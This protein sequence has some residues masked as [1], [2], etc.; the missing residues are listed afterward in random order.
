MV[1]LP[2]LARPTTTTRHPLRPCLPSVLSIIKYN[3]RC[4]RRYLRSFYP[5]LLSGSV[6]VYFL[7]PL[8]LYF[9][10]VPMLHNSKGCLPGARS[11]AP[12]PS[13]MT[14]TFQ[15]KTQ[16]M[17]QGRRSAIAKWCDS[18]E[19]RS[20]SV[21]LM[22]R[23]FRDRPAFSQGD[24]DDRYCVPETRCQASFDSPVMREQMDGE[25]GQ[26]FKNVSLDQCSDGTTDGSAQCI[27]S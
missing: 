13:L 2:E 9:P 27:I 16:R 23:T 10:V 25:A 17:C 7:F 6:A 18:R 8:D 26:F 14:V 20:N 4:H 3:P 11:I 21:H 19:M 5:R 24:L 1:R 15:L 22:A 12:F